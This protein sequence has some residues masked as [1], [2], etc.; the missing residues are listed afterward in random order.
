MTTQLGAARS[1]WAT[2]GLVLLMA[3]PHASKTTP[4]PAEAGTPSKSQPSGAPGG[5]PEAMTPAAL[6]KPGA[7]RQLQEALNKH[8]VEAPENGVFDQ[9]TQKSLIQFQRKAKIAETGLP[10]RETLK[11]LG[12]DA[13]SIYKSNEH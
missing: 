4:A 13:D 11:Q 1:R 7:V 8:G 3:C 12:L 2:T 5:P 9:A 6:L 10:D